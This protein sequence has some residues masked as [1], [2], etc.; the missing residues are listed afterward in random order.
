MASPLVNRLTLIAIVAGLCGGL[1]VANYFRTSSEPEVYNLNA[2]QPQPAITMLPE[3]VLPDLTGEIRRVSEWYGRPLIINFWATWCAPCR[4]EMPIL[5][6]AHNTAGESGPIVIGVAVD[7]SDD[8]LT[9]VTESGYTYP[10]L[11]GQQEAL[12]ITELFGFDFLGLPF[13]VFTT[14]TG[15][16]LT[17]HLGELHA[18][19]LA[20]YLAIYKS[21]NNQIITIES[22]RE[23]MSVVNQPQDPA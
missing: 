21:L 18:E 12:D 4:R 6:L 10:M 17:V 2:P 8:A 15:E 20:D 9:Y 3:I 1:I 16:I 5:Q 19:Q 22:A 13:T 23:Q 11:V 7:R 14:E